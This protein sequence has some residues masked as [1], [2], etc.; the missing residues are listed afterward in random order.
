VLPY[1]SVSMYSDKKYIAKSFKISEKHVNR[2]IF[3]QVF[4]KR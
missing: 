3:L 1:L 4:K 2:Y